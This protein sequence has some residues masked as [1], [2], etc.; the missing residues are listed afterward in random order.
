MTVLSAKKIPTLAQADD[1]RR[2]LLEAAGDLDK[3]DVFGDLVL[4][5]TFIRHEKTEGGIIRPHEN[6]QEDEWQSKVGLVLKKGPLAWSEWEEESDRG[7]NARLGSWVVFNIK[8]GWPVQVNG[9]PCRFIPYERLRMRVS[10]PDV[11]F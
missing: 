4:V 2:A 10:S 9:T 6:V 1:P 5:G 3:E 11:V 8:D 7:S